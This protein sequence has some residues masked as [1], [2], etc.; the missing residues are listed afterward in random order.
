[1]KNEKLSVNSAGKTVSDFESMRITDFELARKAAASDVDA[2]EQLYWRH[3]RRVF[4]IC[5]RMTKNADEAEDVTQQIFLNLFKKIGTFRGDSA[6]STWLYRITVNQMLMHI[7]A[8]KL[9]KEVITE[10]GELPEVNYQLASKS[11]NAN[12]IISRLQLNE[13]IGKLAEGY[14][15]VLILHDIKGFE[16]QE[17]AQMLGCAAGTSKSQ[18]HKARQVLRRLLTAGNAS[19][20][21]TLKVVE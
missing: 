8:G 9:C 13:A 18:L 20:R 6:F 15:K 12:Q 2:F 4:G 3:H 1:M 19:N 16:H 7:R 21:K 14:R 11:G 5:V 17:I 10:D